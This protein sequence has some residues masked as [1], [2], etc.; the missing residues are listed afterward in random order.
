MVSAINEAA[1]S[2]LSNK[3]KEA[4]LDCFRNVAWL[5]GTDGKE[6]FDALLEALNI[7][8]FYDTWKWTYPGNLYKYNGTP[9]YLEGSSTDGVLLDNSTT[10]ARIKRSMFTNRGKLAAV[11]RV[12]ISGDVFPIPIPSGATSVSATIN[13]STMQVLLQQWK[14]QG[15][16][17]KLIN[18]SAWCTGTATLNLSPSP[19]K[20]LCVNIRY[21]SSASVFQTEPQGFEITFQ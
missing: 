10:S 1:Q 8:D 6:S 18:M 20:F 21:N 19:D 12:A 15:N 9:S 16:V 17:Y 2:G 13:P 14:L 3:V 5:N 4:I 7:S 11:E